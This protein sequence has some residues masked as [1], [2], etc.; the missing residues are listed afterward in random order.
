[1]NKTI[2]ISKN[3]FLSFLVFIV[4][5]CSHDTLL[6]GTNQ[7]NRFIMARKIIPFLLI[8]CLLLMQQ[9]IHIKKKALFI[10]IVTLIIPII[11][12]VMNREDVNNYIYRAAVMMC[13]LLFVLNG[14]Q[15]K[16]F[17][18]YNRI[19]YL[20]S[21][22]SIGSYVLMIFLPGIASK[23]PVVYNTGGTPYYFL[24]FS[25][26]NSELHYG[27]IRNSSIFR[28]PGVF[29][30]MLT[31]ALLIEIIIYKRIRPRIIG[32]FCV[33]MVTTYSTAGYIILLVLFAYY[34]LFEK[35]LVNKTVIFIAMAVI[36]GILARYTDLLTR[37]G[38]IFDKFVKG[39]NS[40]GSWL[41]RWSSLTESISI[42]LRNPLFGI[43]RYAL[44]DVVLNVSGVYRAVDNTN[45]LLVGFAA[46]GLLFGCLI[47]WGCWRFIWTNQKQVLS[48]IILFVVL[49]MALFNEDMGQNVVFYILVFS[50]LCHSKKK[51]YTLQSNY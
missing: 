30:V 5:F 24:G 41:A 10:S 12:C 29:C 16:F 17:K 33:A 35:K 49:L 2:K 7:D 44:Y 28:E 31:L 34:V 37:S 46:Y 50:G 40:Y 18:A 45:T 39:S 43:G 25:L 27:M 8:F 48:A 9:V 22:W 42:A 51:R 38:P 19:I 21:V 15:V 36:V 4:I 20:L 26:V 14:W 32:T 47:T 3:S 1:M 6:F 13:A 11:S 23:F